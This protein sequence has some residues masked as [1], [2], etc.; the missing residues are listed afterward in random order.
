MKNKKESIC[1]YC[2]NT[3]YYSRKNMG[4]MVT[5]PCGQCDTYKI[6]KANFMKQLERE[7]DEIQKVIKNHKG[8]TK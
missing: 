4:G 6:W 3:G 2:R 7:Q 5:E 1:K 8:K